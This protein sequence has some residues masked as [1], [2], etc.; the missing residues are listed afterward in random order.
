MINA[1]HSRSWAKYGDSP[2]VVMSQTGGRQGCKLGSILFNATY[3]LALGEVHARL[4][5]AGIL[6]RLECHRAPFWGNC[7]LGKAVSKEYVVDATFV[8][9]E[10]IVLFAR[11]PRKLRDAISLL[12]EV[13]VGTVA[14]FQMLINWFKD[15]WRTSDYQRH[16][17]R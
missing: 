10:C 13:L 5:E 6:L 7:S 8:D 16:F 1:L 4:R 15:N 11:C 12:L 14:K 3:S 2:S 9:D 17:K